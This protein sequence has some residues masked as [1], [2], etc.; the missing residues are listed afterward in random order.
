[1]REKEECEVVKTK[2]FRKMAKRGQGQ[3][4][5][6]GCVGRGRGR[7]KGDTTAKARRSLPNSE[8]ADL[9]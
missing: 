3:V 2:D 1:M 9:L 7:E 4:E 8:E 6:A 5:Q